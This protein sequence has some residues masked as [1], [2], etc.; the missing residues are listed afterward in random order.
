MGVAAGE[1][2]SWWDRGRSDVRP[3]I[4]FPMKGEGGSRR[5]STRCSA[6]RLGLGGEAKLYCLGR[7]FVP[8]RI[9]QVVRCGR[10][11]PEVAR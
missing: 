2:G 9:G 8:V 10:M 1:A 5:M 7:A 11:E 3:Q 6:G 4:C